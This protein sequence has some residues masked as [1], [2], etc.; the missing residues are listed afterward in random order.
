MHY[1]D[2]VVSA[3]TVASGGCSC[4]DFPGAMPVIGPTVTGL[5]LAGPRCAPFSPGFR[6]AVAHEA[7]LFVTQSGAMQSRDDWE[8]S[9][10]EAKNA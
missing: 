2:A 10:N 9:W 8:V 3:I 1:D 5:S 4:E 7:G 6:I